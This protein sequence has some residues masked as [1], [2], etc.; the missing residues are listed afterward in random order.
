MPTILLKYGYLVL[1]S[2][3]GCCQNPI[4]QYGSVVEFVSSEFD[5]FILQKDDKVLHHG[6][7]RQNRLQ[8]SCMISYFL[9]EFQY[10]QKNH[11]QHIKFMSHVAYPMDNVTNT[12]ANYQNKFITHG[13]NIEI[14]Q[15]LFFKKR[16]I[17]SVTFFITL[18]F[19]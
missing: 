11:L 18:F 14:E 12:S 17:A 3:R 6:A 15:T 7:N 1:M 4:S 5:L 19:L 16:I 9:M 10:L 2:Y 8:P 13:K